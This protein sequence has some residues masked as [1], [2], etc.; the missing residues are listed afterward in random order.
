MDNPRVNLRVHGRALL[1]TTTFLGISVCCSA[2]F[3]SPLHDIQRR[4]TGVVERNLNARRLPK[5]LE[6]ALL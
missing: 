2:K 6:G 3:P 4:G 1:S 5:K